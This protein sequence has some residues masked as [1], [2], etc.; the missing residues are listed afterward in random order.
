MG[1]VTK[2]KQS[3]SRNGCITCKAKRLK[4]D[5]VKP[6]CQQCHKRNVTC[7]GY[8]KDFKWRAFEE[9]AFTSKPT[10]SPKAKKSS[11][12][13]AKSSVGNPGSPA[14][15]ETSGSTASKGLPFSKSAYQLPPQPR[16]SP[17]SR[18]PPQPFQPTLSN[19]FVYDQ[20]TYIPDRYAAP[21][22]QYQENLQPIS[23]PSTINSVFDDGSALQ[24]TVTTASSFSSG[25]SP[26]LI[27]LLL[28]GTDLNAPPREYM[29]Y[30]PQQSDIPYQP[31]G[32]P[33]G[34]AQ[35]V[36]HVP[37]DED[38]VEEIVRQPDPAEAWVM[39]L[40][41]PSPSNSSTSS[42]SS[43]FDPLTSLSREPRMLPG[44]PEMLMMRFDQQTCGILSVKD[45]PT[46]NPWRTM[47]WPLA[48]ESPA[49]YHAISSMTAFHTSKERPA[50][51]VEGMEHM[52]KSIRHLSLG[53]ESMRTD[54]ALATTL[55][56]AFSESWDQHISTGIEHLR[57]AK[58]LVNQALMKHRQ[59]VLQTEDRERL[60][61]LCNTWVYMDVIARLTSIDSDDS[62]CFDTV[63]TPCGP[64]VINNEVDPLLGCASTL[65]P[66]IGRVA[67]LIRKVRM[68]STNSFTVIS[69]ANDLKTAVEDWEPPTFFEPPEDPTS[70]IQHS[71]QTAE[72]YRWATLLYLHQAVPE[73]PSK[74]AAELAKKVL[75]YLATVPLNSRA[76]IIQIYPLLAAGCEAMGKEDRA[77][78]KNRWEVM[79]QRMLI[80]NVDRCWEVVRE[81]W[82][83]RDADELEKGRQRHRRPA[84][85]N[86][87]P[88]AFSTESMK[89]KF[90]SE[91]DS[92][93]FGWTDGYSTSKRRATFSG[94]VPA[95]SSGVM[96][97]PPR[98]KSVDTLEDIDFE[99]T[100]RGRLHWIGVMKDWKWEVLLG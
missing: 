21:S 13:C 2:P 73:I 4:C 94:M 97:D 96:F 98:K 6:T 26:R 23:T 100:V 56:L 41:S 7:G 3:K 39:R 30:R 72:S 53:L 64:F 77:W 32:Y 65:F 79:M 12:T 43:R 18:F 71:L 34:Q 89:R 78:V 17:E 47:I 37:D 35:D 10:S 57:G 59:N 66:L 48:R 93:P 19:T 74:S 49:L 86:P 29:D 76:I 51:R 40:P 31:G 58:I 27:D 50:M 8:K 69:Q 33:F 70:E 15:S 84:F 88:Y 95:S 14:I 5:E 83:R 62:N 22:L 44:S 68:S 54:T 82:D 16:I 25:Q 87:A 75:V 67:N 91:D 80:G 63:I 90:R 42:D 11:P 38:D 81:V 85:R 24:S 45:G 60:K 9:T 1:G 36:A 92:S 99:R 28:P 61:F 52:R 20:P 46:E 55:V